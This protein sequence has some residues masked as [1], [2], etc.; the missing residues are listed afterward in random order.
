[1]INSIKYLF[2]QKIYNFKKMATEKQV[3]QNKFLQLLRMAMG[4]EAQQPDTISDREW[5]E[6]HEVARMQTL[7]GVLFLAI[8]TLPENIRPPFKLLMQWTLEAERI[9]AANKILNNACVKL[10]ELF[11]QE[12]H[13]TAIL[14]GQA[15]ALLY[16]DTMCRQP[17][18]IDIWVDGGKDNVLAMLNNMKLGYSLAYHHAHLNENLYDAP[19]EVHFRPSSG[20]YNPF[21]NNVLQKKLYQELNDLE[22]TESGFYVPS[23]RF[24]MLMQLAHL[25]RH[26]LSEELGMRHVV[27]YYILLSKYG[28]IISESEIREIGLYQFARAL[29]WVLHEMF[30]INKEQMLV[31]PDEK[32]GR[33]L[34]DKLFLCGNFGRSNSIIVA[35]EG[36]NPY[37]RRLLLEIDKWK[38]LPLW[39]NEII[40]A[41]L[42]YWK[43]FFKMLPERIRRGTIHVN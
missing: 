16:S 9:R 18:D 38:K 15:N 42:V 35:L 5:M 41:D 28:N 3:V 13:Q 7:L 25:R 40:W 24:A 2:L 12:G 29:M 4:L 23:G 19:V 33:M 31:D 20:N 37:K 22:L 10:T 21:T 1:M 30:G 6:I 39:G 43:S 36:V 14:K 26:F 32:R 11:G 27:D 17:G 34:L 8:K